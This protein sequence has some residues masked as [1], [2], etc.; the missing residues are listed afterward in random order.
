MSSP[1]G[2]SVEKGNVTDV[3]AGDESDRDEW[4]CSR[5]INSIELGP[6][7]QQ[8][9]LAIK[10]AKVGRSGLVCEEQLVPKNEK[11]GRERNVESRPR[12]EEKE[13]EGEVDDERESMVM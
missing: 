12:V 10:G 4:R 13:D 6:L 3:K 9:P 2:R 7:D 1:A 11:A 5:A 8:E